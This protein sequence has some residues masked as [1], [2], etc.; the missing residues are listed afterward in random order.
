[1]MLSNYRRILYTYLMMLM[2]FSTDIDE[3]ASK[4]CSQHC[5]NTKGSYKCTC[6]EGYQLG[7]NQKTCK[8]KGGCTADIKDAKYYL[9]TLYVTMM[10]YQICVG[11]I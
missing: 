7:R 5:V 9:C 4:P 10:T 6:A 8:A 1:M 2:V 3:C 11:A